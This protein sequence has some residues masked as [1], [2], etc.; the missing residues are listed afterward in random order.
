[1]GIHTYLPSSTQLLVVLNKHTIHILFLF[2]SKWMVELQNII[3]EVSLHLL[4][5]FHPCVCACTCVT[6]CVCS[7]LQTV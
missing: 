6:G 1:M 4:L 2:N 7:C 5:C 3:K